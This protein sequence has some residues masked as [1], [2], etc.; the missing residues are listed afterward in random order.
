[1]KNESLQNTMTHEYMKEV[2]KETL[3]TYK[4]EYNQGLLTQDEYKECIKIKALFG[5][6]VD[7]LKAAGVKGQ[8]YASD[9][10]NLIKEVKKD[11]KNQQK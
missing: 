5:V 2:V 7:N 1:M 10:I 9:I 6:V 4:E 11:F 8:F 3:T